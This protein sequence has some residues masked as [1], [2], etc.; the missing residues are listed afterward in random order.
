MSRLS[1]KK[2]KRTRDREVQTVTETFG[3]QVAVVAQEVDILKQLHHQVW[4]RG[5]G[6]ISPD[7]LREFHLVA[8]KFHQLIKDS[9]EEGITPSQSKYDN[10]AFLLL[11]SFAHDV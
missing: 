6:S 3:A 7:D 2:K 11:F 4:Y 5:I 1:L 10:F 9:M 8:E